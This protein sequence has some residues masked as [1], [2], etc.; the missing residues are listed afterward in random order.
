MKMIG[1]NNYTKKRKKRTYKYEDLLYLWLQSIR[2]NLKESS[3]S[4]YI[5]LIQSH[6]IPGLGNHYLEELTT[7]KLEQEIERLLRNGKIH[8]KDGL[9]AKMVTDILSIIK[10]SV[11]WCKEEGYHI[12]CEITK[13]KVKRELREMRVLG[14]KEQQ[15]LQGILTS[16]MNRYKLGVL[17]ALYTGVRIGELCGLRWEDIDLNEQVLHVRRALQRIKNL[18]GEGRKTRI[19]ISSPKRNS[20]RDIPLPGCLLSYLKKYEADSDNYLLTGTRKYVE[21]RL[22]QYHFKRFVAES[23]ID[24]ANFHSLRHTFATR[25]VE[26]EFDVKSLSEILGHSDVNMTLN[27]YV[28]SSYRLKKENMN[29]LSILL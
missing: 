26:A 24:D 15:K 5:Q 19:L 28:H 21:P 10:A 11:I 2:F 22:L 14:I 7:Q 20:V 4:R 16:N 23:E 6:I 17:V 18:S 8:S 12:S 1:M 25:C 13:I 27:R 9:S 29:K 3:Y